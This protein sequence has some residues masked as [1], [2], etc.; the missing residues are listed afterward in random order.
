MGTREQ[1]VHQSVHLW[2]STVFNE[3]TVRGKDIIDVGALDVNGSL[4]SF[5]M[6]FSPRSYTGFD[7]RPGAGVDEVCAAENLP[8]NIADVAVCT[9]MLEHAENWRE[10]L[11]G[12]TR[13]LRPGGVLALTTRSPGFPRHDHPGDYWRFTTSVMSQALSLGCG[14]FVSRC[15]DDPEA[16]GVFAVASRRP[17]SFYDIHAIPVD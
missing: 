3:S 6:G 14:L 12:L 10:A 7:I 5:I 11:L 4:K 2:A 13:A 16:P 15:E 9:E 17:A 8:D 1:V